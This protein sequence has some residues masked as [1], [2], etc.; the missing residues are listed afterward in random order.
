VAG[1]CE[2]GDKCS[3]RGST[4]LLSVPLTMHD[5]ECNVYIQSVP[6]KHIRNLNVHN[7]HIN[8]DRIVM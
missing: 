4:K 1:C 3:G 2:D 8:R 6:E 5:S 7:S